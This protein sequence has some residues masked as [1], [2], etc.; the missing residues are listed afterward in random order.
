[1]MAGGVFCTFLLLLVA[2][3]SDA[4]EKC[5]QIQLECGRHAVC[6][7]IQ[8]KYLQ[9]CATTFATGRSCSKVCKSAHMQLLTNSIGSKYNYCDC[10]TNRICSLWTANLLKAC[11]RGVRPVIPKPTTPI[12][13]VIATQP[14]VMTTEQ[15]TMATTPMNCLVLQQQCGADQ[16]CG[17]LQTKYL[18]MCQRSLATG[19]S[20][21]NDCIAAQME[22]MRNDIG[23][24][25][26]NCDCGGNTICMTYGANLVKA[27][28]TPTD[29]PPMYMMTTE[30]P[31]CPR[32]QPS[33]MLVEKS[34]RNVRKLKM[35]SV[36][37]TIL[38]KCKGGYDLVGD[39]SR[40][41]LP[42][43]QYSAELP[44]CVKSAGCKRQKVKRPLVEMS[45]PRVRSNAKTIPV[46]T[47]LSYSCKKHYSLRGD[48]TRVCQQDGQYSAEM[49]QCEGT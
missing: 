46:G 8:S 49:P 12:P 9:V 17:P 33:K 42:N 24:Y 18:Q 15:A 22:L 48:M 47:T 34:P 20:C 2:S 6:G 3:H 1:M 37:T 27:C 40:E 45:S 10:E 44:R 35:I 23:S 36:G 38:Y 39:A 4:E 28:Y 5:L 29:S 7:P 30:P 11:Y 21:T 32:E 14:E 41:C 16:T 31:A 43:G 19:M 25:Y 13:E 26:N